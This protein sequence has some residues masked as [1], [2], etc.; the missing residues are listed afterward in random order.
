MTQPATPSHEFERLKVRQKMTFMVN[1]YE[2]IR[3]DGAGNDLGLLC[4][5]EQKRMAMKEQVTFF[6]DAA[7]THPLFGFKARKVVD[8]GSRYDIVDGLGQPIGWFRKDFTASLGRSTWHLGTSEGFECVGQERNAKV[9][10]LRRVW[11]FIPLAGDLPVPW[12]FHFDF[13]AADGSVVM[14]STKRVG[15]KDTYFVDLP[16]QQNGW[17]LDWRV[18]SAMA[19]ALDA[20]QSR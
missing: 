2:V 16:A 8:L 1:R 14:S 20:L 10:V 4:F 19:V 17:R 15:L 5:A 9:A 13:Q 7:K 12:L 18:A 3:T 11:D 6:T